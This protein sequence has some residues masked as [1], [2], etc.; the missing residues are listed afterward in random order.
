[1]RLRAL[2]DVLENEKKHKTGTEF[3]TD[4]ETGLVLIKYGYAEEVKE[5]PARKPARKTTKE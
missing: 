4:K 2:A 3:E 1:M 5:K